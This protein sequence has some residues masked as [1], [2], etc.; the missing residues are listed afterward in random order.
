MSSPAD[1]H[2]ALLR[3][4]TGQAGADDR[5]IHADVEA[6][7]YDWQAPVHFRGE[8]I[9]QLSRWSAGLARRLG[10]WLGERL[11][12]EIALT[13]DP[14]G[15]HFAHQIDEQSDKPAEFVLPLAAEGTACGR[16]GL[17]RSPAA[18][19][20]AR[21]LG[22][23]GSGGDERELSDL[24]TD[25]LTNTAAGLVELISAA[26]AERGG[27]KLALDGE[28]SDEPADLPGGRDAEYCQFLFRSEEGEDP[29]VRLAIL[30]E[31]LDPLVGAAGGQPVE[32]TPPEQARAFM[33]E[34]FERTSLTATAL[35]ASTE[36]T[37]RDVLEIQ[38]GDVLLLP[39]LCDEAID[40]C[41]DGRAVSRGFPVVSDGRLAVQIDH[42]RAA[43]A[44][45]QTPPRPTTNKD[46]KEPTDGGSNGH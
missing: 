40:V 43:T 39:K 1:A 26:A 9:A 23:A 45:P 32:K 5:P 44:S 14:A 29:L 34:H 4:L 37:M 24:E 20:V 3:A 10:Q 2:L 21:L 46:G 12:Q 25:L 42:V 19:W 17:A 15:Q 8:Q 13:A 7:D 41:V 6:Q 22:G 28:I 27:P 38:P 35:V 18:G 30:C 16:I 36:V 11:R 33:K 31:T